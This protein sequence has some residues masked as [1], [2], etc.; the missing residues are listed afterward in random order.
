MMPSTAEQ[1]ATSLVAP[2]P[3]DTEGLMA[4]PDSERGG[5]RP[6]HD[7][8]AEV[9]L[10]GTEGILDALVTAADDLS[11]VRLMSD[12][13]LDRVLA[14]LKL[15]EMK[16]RKIKH[17]VQLLREKD[18]SSLDF[19]GARRE[20][21]ELPAKR[22]IETSAAGPD[23]LYLGIDLSTQSATGV[24]MDASL[25]VP[26]FTAS[27]HC[28]HRPSGHCTHR[29]LATVS[30]TAR[31]LSPC[32][33]VSATPHSRKVVLRRS[34]NFDEA[35]AEFGTSAGMHVRHMEEGM[36]VT[37]PV[38]MWLKVRAS[39]PSSP[40]HSLPSS[41]LPTV[42]HHSPLSPALPNSNPNPNPNPFP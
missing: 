6:I 42:P 20:A 37:S 27:F 4:T 32:R 9:G 7:W 36:R 30:V 31:P 38:R 19:G 13:D 2:Y 16:L 23:A 28:F 25:K 18:A 35:C 8:L 12:N 33:D 34:I 40:G 41:W 29:L 17:E 1:S 3:I 5:A 21:V 11:E 22:A 24:V 26:L 39:P 14:P 15:K 10:D